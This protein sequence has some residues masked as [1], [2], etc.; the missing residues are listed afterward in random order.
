MEFLIT[1]QLSQLLFDHTQINCED[2]TCIAGCSNRD[3]KTRDC[4]CR[5]AYIPICGM[6]VCTV[7]CP[8]VSIMR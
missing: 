8:N 1:P 7:D 5:G 4:S 6:K 2:F 3:C